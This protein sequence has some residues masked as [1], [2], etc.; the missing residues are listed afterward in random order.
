VHFTFEKL[1]SQENTNMEKKEEMIKL[2]RRR[3]KVF[4]W[5]RIQNRYWREWWKC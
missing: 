4:I 5:N 1:S 2:R 3:R